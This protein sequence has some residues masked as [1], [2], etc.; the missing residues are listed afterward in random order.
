MDRNDV[1][2][3]PEW[4]GQRP[5]PVRSPLNLSSLPFVEAALEKGCSPTDSVVTCRHGSAGLRRGIA[6][7]WF[8]CEA[9][10]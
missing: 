9:T 5:G 2:L 10:Q 8:R 7:R 6:P 1:T 4:A 3:K